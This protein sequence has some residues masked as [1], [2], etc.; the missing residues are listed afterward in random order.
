MRLKRLGLPLMTFALVF[1]MLSAAAVAQSAQPSRDGASRKQQVVATGR[2]LGTREIQQV[3]TWQAGGAAHLAIE[4]VTASRPHILWQIDGEDSG[5]TV[6]SVRISDL[7]GDGVPEI[8]SLWWKGSTGGLLRVFHWDRGQRSFV[9]LQVED[10]INRARSYRIVPVPGHRSS[11][12]VVDASRDPGT[13][14]SLGEYELRGSRLVRVGGAPVVTTKTESGIEGQ[15]VISPTHPGPVRM[16]ESGT[17]PYKTTLVIWDA[18][19]DREVARLETGSD[20]RFRVALPPGTYT[21]RPAQQK[22][23]FLPRGSD[24]TVTVAPGKF[25]QVTINFDSGMR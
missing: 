11:H 7:D 14:P 8:A 12:L 17:A 21:V 3:I 22:G 5:S 13:K 20:G 16:G 1:G 4:T 2:F 25:V 9:E 24:E 6:D 10:E 19:N 23:R 18:T 15:A